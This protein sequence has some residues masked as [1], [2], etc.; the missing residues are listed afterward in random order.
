MYFGGSTRAAGGGAGRSWRRVDAAQVC[1][2]VGFVVDDGAFECNAAKYTLRQSF[3]D[4]NQ[5]QFVPANTFLFELK[6]LQHNM[7]SRWVALR[8]QQIT[9]IRNGRENAMRLRIAKVVAMVM[10]H[11]ICI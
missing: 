3:H 10:G 6:C 11:L 8:S 9:E 1:S 7:I 5:R 2:N 4:N